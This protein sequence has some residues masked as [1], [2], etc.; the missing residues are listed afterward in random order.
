VAF[1]PNGKLLA[2]GSSDNNIRVWD[3]HTGRTMQE[4]RGH[5]KRVVSLAWS[6]DGS[7]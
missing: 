6:P 5:A 3:P 2:S 4:L 7:D 1:S